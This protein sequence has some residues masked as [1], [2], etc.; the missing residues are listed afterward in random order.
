MCK[1][2]FKIETVNDS[3]YINAWTADRTP[4]WAL[5]SS[6]VYKERTVV[7][8]IKAARAAKH[9]LLRHACSDCGDRFE[10]ITDYHAHRAS[11]HDY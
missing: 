5:G 8:I 7:N 6:G 10:F 9:D 1:T 4:H 2:K 11:R 3:F